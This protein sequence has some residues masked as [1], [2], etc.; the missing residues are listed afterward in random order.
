MVPYCIS[1]FTDEVSKVRVAA[2]DSVIDVLKECEFIKIGH[3]DYYVF[4]TYIFPAFLKLL[5]DPDKV[6]QL[7]FIEKLPYLVNIGKM[8][9]T[10][11][12]K[13]EITNLAKEEQ[14]TLEVNKEQREQSLFARLE[15]EVPLNQDPPFHLERIEHSESQ[16]ESIPTEPET[17]IEH[18]IDEEFKISTSKSILEESVKNNQ[19]YMKSIMENENIISM[20]CTTIFFYYNNFIYTHPKFYVGWNRKRFF[21]DEQKIR[22]VLGLGYNMS[23][24]DNDSELSEDLDQENEVEREFEVLKVKII[25]VVERI[26]DEQ[27][28]LKNYVLMCN[29]EDI[30]EFLGENLISESLLPYVLSIP[31]MKD[32]QLTLVT[33][34]AL[35]VLSHYVIG[36]NELKYIVTC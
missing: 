23:L 29:I 5:D 20:F 8:L 25:E 26:I 31:N 33:L 13:Q 30:A 15:E 7:K 16:D 6:I 28:V 36:V 3:T 22:S 17:E 27:D 14:N 4:D 12:N 10:S 1:C 2:I 11:V 18:D 34:K 24:N 35:R 9:I 19:E 32:S 21:T